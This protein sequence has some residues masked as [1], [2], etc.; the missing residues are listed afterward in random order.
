MEVT[1]EPAEWQKNHCFLCPFAFSFLT[2][3]HCQCFFSFSDILLVSLWLHPLK[4]NRQNS[5]KNNGNGRSHSKTNKMTKKHWYWMKA[6][7]EK[8]NSIKK[9]LAKDVS[10]NRINRKSSN[11]EC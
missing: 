8:Q 11:K 9:T 10:Y 4:L 5:Y 3:I 1:T 6:L 7:K 2:F